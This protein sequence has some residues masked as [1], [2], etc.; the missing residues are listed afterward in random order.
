MFKTFLNQLIEGK[1]LN[2]H[3]A[4][5]VMD[6]IM[7]GNATP[8]QISSFLSVLRFRGETVDELIGFVESMRA[9]AISLEHSEDVLDTCGTGGDGAKTFNISTTVALI[10]ASMGVKV[11]K[12]GNR[13]MSSKSGSADVLE[14]LGIPVQATPNEALHALQTNNLCFLFAP[15]Y[16]ASMKYAAGPRK[17]L[18]FRTVF[19]ILGPL[20]NPAN[21]KRQLLGVYDFELARKMAHALKELGV[22]RTLLVTGEGGLDELS[23]T[24]PSQL[25]KVEEDVVEEFTLTPEDVG[26]TR[27]N[28]ESIQVASIE[29]SARLIREVLHGTANPSAMGI[30]LLNT[31]AAL[32]VAGKAAS[33]KE[34][35]E[36]AREAIE[37]GIPE[38]YYHQIRT[39]EDILREIK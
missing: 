23:I 12:H 39:E 33:I 16:H 30:V 5:L 31:G 18:G 20:A 17:E 1:T 15:L 19:N 29:E 34:G 21:T 4:R 24:G 9:H 13:A 36:L 11:A 2:R 27:G 10:L 14:A 38:A 28:L 37:A 25:L 6:D 35:V 3:E 22:T 7:N 8:S 32:Y 26:L